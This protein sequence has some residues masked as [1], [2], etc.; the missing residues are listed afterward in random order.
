MK[1][2]KIEVDSSITYIKL[3][4]KASKSLAKQLKLLE[5]NSLYSFSKSTDLL[6]LFV[7]L[8]CSINIDEIFE[9]F[10]IPLIDINNKMN[11]FK[12]IDSGIYK[13]IPVYCIPTDYLQYLKTNTYDERLREYIIKILK[14]RFL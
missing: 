5:D 14:K 9:E 6:Y 3:C 7:D 11:N 8:N 1:Y 12:K 2:R 4:S 13:N 10:A